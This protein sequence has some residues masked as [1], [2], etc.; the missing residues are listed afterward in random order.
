MG[1]FN[2]SRRRH[3][4][5]P[6]PEST[7]TPAAS[8]TA[9]RSGRRPERFSVSQAIPR[10]SPEGV[11]LR[12]VAAR[13]F[14][15]EAP[16]KKSHVNELFLAAQ[17]PI[18]ERA[19][20]QLNPLDQRPVINWL[21]SACATTRLLR[22]VNRGA[23]AHTQ[24]HK[25]LRRERLALSRPRRMDGSKRTTPARRCRLRSD[26]HVATSTQML[27]FKRLDL[28]RSLSPKIDF[29]T[30][31]RWRQIPKVATA[32]RRPYRAIG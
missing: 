16:A 3:A 6:R 12:L 25:P 30:K 17:R 22:H 1:L 20:W 4:A 28:A 31:R 29:A 15:R 7:S 27:T 11:A 8:R 13:E 32:C 18:V 9:T 26:S 14:R 24:K 21:A 10:C 19:L 23:P 2:L 5:K